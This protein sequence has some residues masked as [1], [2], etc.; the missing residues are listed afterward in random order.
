[1]ASS[2]GSSPFICKGNLHSVFHS[3]R[4][5]MVPHYSLTCISL[6]SDV[7]HLFLCLLAISLSLGKRSGPLLIFNIVYLGY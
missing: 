4:Y 5:E 2:Y 1:M 7:E 6:I 3:G